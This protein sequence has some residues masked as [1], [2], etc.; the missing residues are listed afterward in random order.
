MAICGYTYKGEEDVYTL[1]TSPEQF[2]DQHGPALAG[3]LV[4]TTV[5]AFFGNGG[6]RVY[7]CRV[8]ASDAVAANLDIDEP[9][10]AETPLFA[11][12]PDGCEG[13][14]A[15]ADHSGTPV[16]QF[17]LTLVTAPLVDTLE[18]NFD[19]V[20]TAATDSSVMAGNGAEL[21]FALKPNLASF[22]DNVAVY[23]AFCGGVAGK[24]NLH[25]ANTGGLYHG[26]ADIINPVAAGSPTDQANF[27]VKVNA[28]R[29]KMQNHGGNVG[30]AFHLGVDPVAPPGAAPVATY[31]GAVILLRDLIDWYN[32]HIAKNGAVVHAVADVANGAVTTGIT[33]PYNSGT[34]YRL[35]PG[36]VEI[37]W[38]ANTIYDKGDGTF[39]ATAFLGAGTVNYTTG[40]I[41]LTALAAP[42]ALPAV[43]NI[44]YNLVA[45]RTTKTFWINSNDEFV[46][47]A[48][49]AVGAFPATILD[50][51]GTNQIDR[52]AK[53]IEFKTKVSS[54]V[55]VPD[56]HLQANYVD[57]VTTAEVDYTKLYWRLKCIGKGSYGNGIQCAFAGEPDSFVSV[58]Y[59]PV[60]DRWE[61]TTGDNTN[62]DLGKY[63]SYS[64][65][66]R[67]ATEIGGTTYEDKEEFGDL[68]LSDPD[69]ANYLPDVVND[70][71]SGS[72]LVEIDTP[73]GTGLPAGLD[74]VKVTAESLVLAGGGA[75]VGDGV[76]SA[77]IGEIVSAHA[78]NGVVPQTLKLSYVDALGATKIV[79]DDGY[80]NLIGWVN[81]GGTNV[82]DYDLGTF[83]VMLRTPLQGAAS[84]AATYYK[85]PAST[86]L[87]YTLIS[88]SDGV[89]LIGSAETVSSALDATNR[90]IYAFKT[91][92][93]PLIGPVVPDF[94]GNA[95]VDNLILAFAEVRKNFFAPLVVPRGVT[96]TG[97]KHY[98]K[99]VLGANTSYGAL[100]APWVK[101]LDP[102]LDTSVTFPPLGHIAGA[103][104]R[105]D[106]ERNVGETP[107]GTEKGKLLQTIGLETYFTK[108]EV[109][110]LNSSGVNCIVDWPQTGRVI[111]GGRS[112]SYTPE[113]RYL[114]AR[115]LFEYV[116]MSLYL[117]TWWA[118]FEN[119]GSNLRLRLYSQVYN[120]MKRLYS[121]GYF[122]ANA[123][124]E[125][126]AFYVVCNDSNNPTNV[127]SAGQVVVDVYIA[128]STPAE[129]IRLRFTQITQGASA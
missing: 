108:E 128:P 40:A 45:S 20:A 98:R 78:G 118:C 86:E 18:V 69:L 62:P 94:A 110:D 71:L 9:V 85:E 116:E 74:A 68:N 47:A 10:A 6:K 103:Y 65:V 11:P 106:I 82:V 15:V 126:E 113:W 123:K 109:G 54:G 14:V 70:T 122:N 63:L 83:N 23:N 61:D 92:E 76:T 59:D 58:V 111:W 31:A 33:F 56:S 35:E 101:I 81:A 102:V 124:S 19:S 41:S 66:V 21:S 95:T 29:A 99:A 72:K 53:T 87:A 129:F 67:E 24:W 50:V 79:Y 22:A 90:G 112:L 7:T 57:N 105:C 25:L 43:A 42:P 3:W 104:A 44:T 119:N 107:A 13:K 5:S 39:I 17:T 34:D 28:L 49:P 96:A 73:Y 46:D 80:G 120:F 51:A 27:I 114:S 36:S 93:E 97:A 4:P 12:A 84:I 117:S 115:R 48:P 32:L 60:Q 38:G 91:I 64:L 121:E 75:L 52:T 26:I 16:S 77:Y 37:V 89:A 1:S 2:L 8:V 55:L 100:Y 125:R 30:A 88:G 127:V